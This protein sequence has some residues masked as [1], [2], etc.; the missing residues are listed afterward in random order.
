MAKKFSQT[1][2]DLHTTLR[3]PS[4]IFYAQNEEGFAITFGVKT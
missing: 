3:L 4:G 1:S 2:S